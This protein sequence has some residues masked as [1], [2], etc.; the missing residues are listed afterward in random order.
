M[1]KDVEEIQQRWRELLPSK[2]KAEVSTDPVERGNEEWRKELDPAA[3]EVLRHEGTER[4][5]TS[6]LNEEH[7]EGV[8]VC[9]G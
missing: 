1:T 7:R 3:F 9:A 5:F 4:P 2:V 8:F 6:P